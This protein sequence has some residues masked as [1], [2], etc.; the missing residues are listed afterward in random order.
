MLVDRLR[1]PI[2][3][4]SGRNTKAIDFL[5]NYN[6]VGHSFSGDGLKNK[7]AVPESKWKFHRKSQI[8]SLFTHFKLLSSHISGSFFLVIKKN[9]LE[10]KG[11][12]SRWLKS[13]QLK[14]AWRGQ[15]V[16]PHTH[17][18]VFILIH[19]V[20]VYKRPK[21]TSIVNAFWNSNFI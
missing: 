17:S 14:T 2:D 6:S 18:T 1:V 13:S 19:I 5:A 15:E 21:P 3:W 16:R 12:F 20:A 8:K 7:H 10:F 4:V 9:E 11:P